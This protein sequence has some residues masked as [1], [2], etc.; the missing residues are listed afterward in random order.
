MPFTP[1]FTFL[2]I[3]ILYLLIV[4]AFFYLAFRLV[5]AQEKKADSLYDI[6]ITIKKSEL[7]KKGGE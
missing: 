6:S 2:I 1:S 3:P 4:G 5:K 7:F